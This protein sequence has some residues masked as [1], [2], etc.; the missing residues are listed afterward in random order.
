[1]WKRVLFRPTG[2]PKKAFRWLMFHNSGKPR[3]LFRPLVLQSDGRPREPFRR[4]LTSDE[5]QTLPKAV[6]VFEF[7]FDPVEYEASQIDELLSPAVPT[8]PANGS[9]HQQPQNV[10][11]LLAQVARLQLSIDALRRSQHRSELNWQAVTVQLKAIH[12]QNQENQTLLTALSKQPD[13]RVDRMVVPLGPDLLVRTPEGFILMPAEDAALVAAVIGG[14]GRLEP[15]TTTVMQALLSEGDHAIDVG[16]NIGLMLLPAARKV[17]PGGRIIA[18]EPGQRVAGCLA[19]TIALNGITQQVRLHR[20]AAGETAGEANLNVGQV[21][22]HASLLPL[23]GSS[24][25]ERVQIRPLD[26]LVEPGERIRLVKI[27][28]EGFEPQVWRGMRRIIK[29]NPDLA[30]VIEFGPEHL[31]RAGFSVQG[32]LDD[33]QASGFK[34]HEIDEATGHIRPLRSVA[35]LETIYSTNLLLTRKL[36]GGLTLDSA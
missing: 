19:R 2:K 5:Y 34:A 7:D 17:G 36:P 23:P 33:F 22:S 1:M 27:D 11:E 30:V 14:P 15:G 20:C 25:A 21:L 12:G 18:V 6:H 24:T 35:D 16:A 4:W 9:L 13:V 29:D 3:K 32:W 26:E 28:A 31:R 10:E 8:Q